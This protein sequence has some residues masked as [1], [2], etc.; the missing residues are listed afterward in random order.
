VWKLL[1]YFEE[2]R[3]LSKQEAYSRLSEH[4]VGLRFDSPTGGK[5]FPT[6]PYRRF[7][8]FHAST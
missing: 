1:F 4:F 7:K 6:R 5:D 8:V 3:V 2:S